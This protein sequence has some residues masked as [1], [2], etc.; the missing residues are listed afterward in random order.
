MKKFYLLLSLMVLVITS[1]AQIYYQMYYDPDHYATVTANQSM[2]MINEGIL[3]N[4]TTKIREN[5]ESI[6]TNVAKFVL[7]KDMVHRYLTDVN[8]VL[9]DG[10][11]MKYII[12]LV[13]DI[14]SESQMAINDVSDAPQYA[15]FT[16]NSVQSI[17]F[18]SLMIFSEIS[19]LINKGG[20]EA[21]MDN[22][23]RDEILTEITIRLRIM[24]GAL[25][26]I[27]NAI[28]WAK[29]RGFWNTLNPFRSWINQDR[30][31]INRI[32][33]DFNYVSR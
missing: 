12:S 26:G 24:R 3:K 25:F 1:N 32:V 22:A 30:M 31:I 7:I 5:I 17:R 28:K 15:V 23:T 33:R 10:R 2:R 13:D 8:D 9:K 21:L 20:A 6:N 4:Q 19:R 16:T 18:Q 11:Q 27:R 14:I 29:L